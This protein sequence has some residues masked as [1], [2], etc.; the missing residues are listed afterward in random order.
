MLKPRLFGMTRTGNWSAEALGYQAWKAQPRM[1]LQKDSD[2]S[3]WIRKRRHRRQRI[4]D[5]F[6]DA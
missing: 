1:E 4:V 6:N 5:Q 3:V 2:S